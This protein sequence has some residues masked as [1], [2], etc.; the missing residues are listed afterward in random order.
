MWS[1][2]EIL[3]S[4]ESLN[5]QR[6]ASGR[7]SLSVYDRAIRCGAGRDDEGRIVA[8][9]PGD[10]E[11]EGFELSGAIFEPNRLVVFEQDAAEEI[12]V[13]VLRINSIADSNTLWAISGVFAS[14][15]N[16]AE[17]G[18]SAGRVVVLLKELFAS[19]FKR[20]PSPEVVTGLAGELVVILASESP[21]IALKAWHSNP[22]DRYDFSAGTNRVE[23]K[24]SASQRRTHHFSS[25][26]LPPP[27]NV[28]LTVLSVLVDKVE[29]G[30]RIVDLVA[31][32]ASVVG[33]DLRQHL[34]EV[35]TSVLKCPPEFI[36]Y[37]T[38]DSQSARLSVKAF[39]GV[40]VPTVECGLDILSSSWTANLEGIVEHDVSD[41]STLLS[42]N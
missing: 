32:I 23:V 37:V 16:V 25:S 24:S 5:P 22:N 28:N 12:E 20:L 17:S 27:S 36:D 13:A 42:K 2:A 26:Q 21:S 40:N 14:L 11:L 1:T 7:L 34:I 10:S 3:S 41:V 6:A 30:Q 9:F 31:E 38:F 18:G 35:V 33:S 29:V 4:L 19:Q 39:L 15:F 8:V